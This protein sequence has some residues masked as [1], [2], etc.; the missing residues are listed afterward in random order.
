[1]SNTKTTINDVINELKRLQIEHGD[2]DV[3]RYEEYASGKFESA[4]PV[5][6]EKENRVEF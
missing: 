5:Y 4:W 2:S 1:M 3:V 6:N